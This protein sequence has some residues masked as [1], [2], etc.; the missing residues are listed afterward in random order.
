MALI[1]P[2]IRPTQ[3]RQTDA[4]LSAV[5]EAERDRIRE[6]VATTKRDQRER[7][8]YLGG[9]VPFGFKLGDNGDLIEDATQQ[10][11]IARAKA[12]RADGVKLEVIRDTL[13]ADG[14]KLALSALHRV[15]KAA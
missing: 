10:A 11:Q 12:L 14:V 9:K 15:L 4:T 13:A 1:L 2:L 5:A 3:K 6:R 7:G 8:R